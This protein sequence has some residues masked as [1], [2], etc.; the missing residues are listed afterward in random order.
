VSNQ[1]DNLVYRY[2]RFLV[3]EWI[4]EPFHPL[5][6]H[7]LIIKEDSAYRVGGNR[8]RS[9]LSL[10]WPPNYIEAQRMVSLDPLELWIPREDES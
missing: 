10:L 2:L 9:F 8:L 3:G 4:A 6:H 7:P 1:L 5:N